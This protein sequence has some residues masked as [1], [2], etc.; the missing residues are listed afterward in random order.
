MFADG[1]FMKGTV[2]AVTTFS[3]EVTAEGSRGTVGTS[4]NTFEVQ[5]SIVDT[6]K[7]KGCAVDGK[8]VEGGTTGYQPFPWCSTE[9]VHDVL[10]PFGVATVKEPI[11]ALVGADGKSP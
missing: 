5:F 8:S 2:F 4:R 10:V 3:S 7:E 9:L 11:V 6:V 1:F